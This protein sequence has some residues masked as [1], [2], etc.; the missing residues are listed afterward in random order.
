MAT[1]STLNPTL[2]DLTSRMTA[3]GKIDPSII[4]ALNETN[5]MLSDAVW[6]EATGVTENVTTVRSGLPSVAWRRLNY[7]VQPSKSKTKQVSDAL[8]MLEAYAEVDKKL[9]MLN[10]N[11]EAWRASE[12]RPFIEAMNQEFQRAL[13]YGDNAKDSAKILGIMPR[14]STG[15]KAK[16]ENAINVI[17]AGGTGKNLASILLMVWGKNTMYCSYPKGLVG[18]LQHEDLGEVTL[19][20]AD[21]GHYQGYRSHYEW[22][23][24]FTMR[25][26]RYCVRI[27]NI[28]TEA[29]TTDPSSVDLRKY[30]IQAL[31]L[32]P[33]LNAGRA[34]FY[35][36]RTIKTFFE[37][38]LENKSNV[39]LTLDQAE[40]RQVAR[41]RGIPIR[42]VDAM[43][44]EEAKVPF[45]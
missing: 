27:A 36:N 16:A 17:D 5:E 6:N 40:G 44:N 14:F 12:N 35:C 19:D 3:E 43:S 7:G 34:A 42:R 33:S 26:W 25:D 8:G 13:L 38:Q 45:S 39:W 22:N 21:G 1:L 11:T 15:V 31:N 9:A 2:A 37:Q 4:E 28:D 18:G 24:G 23:V 29:L 41:F 30:M 20:D 10:G 32:L